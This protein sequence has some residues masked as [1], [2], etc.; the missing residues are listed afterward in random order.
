MDLYLKSRK[1]S[2]IMWGSYDFISDLDGRTFS[3]H[4]PKFD[5]TPTI[6]PAFNGWFRVSGFTT[7]KICSKTD[8][9]KILNYII[10]RNVGQIWPNSGQKRIGSEL[11]R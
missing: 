1:D 4:I 7:L 2:G 5:L 10:L 9:R 8:I 6:I 3:V 11:A